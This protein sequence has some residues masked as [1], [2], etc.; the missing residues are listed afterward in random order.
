MTLLDDF[1]TRALIGGVGL[2][3]IAGPLG[4]FVIWRRLAYLG[5]A[6]AHTALLGIALVLAFNAAFVAFQLNILV[7]VFAVCLISAYLIARIGDDA[8]ISS[9]SIL[10]ILSHSTLAIGLVLVSLMDWVRVD[11]LHF[12]FGN[13]L[14]ITRLEIL[15]I[16]LIATLFVFVIVMRWR[17]LIASTISQPIA[18]AENM[19]PIQSRY[20]ILVMLAAVIALAMKIVGILL[21][22]ALLIIPAAAARQFSRTPEQMVFV[23]A[24]FGCVAVICGLTLSLKLDLQPGPSIVISALGIFFIS[25]LQHLLRKRTG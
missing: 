15:S 11:I 8:N 16:Y 5:D 4:C 25:V 2:A 1:F 7:G 21:T 6:L 22:V 14:A 9:D 20:L 17:Q 10:G 12:L 24:G 23:A 13:I 18:A 19:N 3:L